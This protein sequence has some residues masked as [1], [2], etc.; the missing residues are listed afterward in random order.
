MENQEAIGVLL[1]NHIKNSQLPNFFFNYMAG[2]IIDDCPSNA[3][4]LY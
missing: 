2:I 4:E 3:E 1:K